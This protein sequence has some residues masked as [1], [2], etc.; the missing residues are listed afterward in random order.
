MD[1]SV[2]MQYISYLLVAIGVMAFVVSA[3]T[4]V[5][6]SLPHCQM[7]NSKIGTINELC[8]YGTCFNTSFFG[9][10]IK[11][12]FSPLLCLVNVSQFSMLL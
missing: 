9:Y 6:K 2:I 10:R 5:V 7:V 8:F 12:N 3:V 1:F 11:T 4:Q